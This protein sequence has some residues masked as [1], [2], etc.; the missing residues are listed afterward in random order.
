MKE[1]S[2]VESLNYDMY[3]EGYE[4]Y[5]KIIEKIF[6]SLLKEIPKAKVIELL[7][8]KKIIARDWEAKGKVYHEN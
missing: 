1:K 2:T 7:K 6:V 4:E 8:K 3:K 5:K